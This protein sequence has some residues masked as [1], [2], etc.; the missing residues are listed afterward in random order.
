MTDDQQDLHRRAADTFG[1]RV[2]AIKDDQWNL[3][4]PNDGWDVRTLVNHL[5]YENRWTPPLL[6]GRT[7]AEIGDRF[8][9][10]LL[11]DDPKAAWEDSASRALAAVAAPG[12]LDRTVHLSSGGTPARE[13]VMQLFADHLVHAWDLARAIGA[14]ERLDPELVEACASWFTS[15]EDGYRSAGA[16]GPRPE[17]PEDAGLQARLL[18]MFGRNL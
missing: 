14:D 10:D 7:I 8:E 17:L 16:I 11:G 9:G 4:T 15:M 12:A 18:A 1:A 6:G 3:A 13:Y 2:E 5:V